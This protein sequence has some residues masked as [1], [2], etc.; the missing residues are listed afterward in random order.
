MMLYWAKSKK[1]KSINI[2]IINKLLRFI[3]LRF[4]EPIKYKYDMVSRNRQLILTYQNN[5]FGIRKGFIAD[6]II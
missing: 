4:K 1:K 5:I 3:L 6:P 2:K